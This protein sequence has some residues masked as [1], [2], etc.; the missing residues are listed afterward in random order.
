MRVFPWLAPSVS[1]AAT[2]NTQVNGGDLIT[3]NATP[4]NGGNY[5]S[6]QW[7]RNSKDVVGALSYTWGAKTL[8]DKDVICL[9][10]TSSYL[11]PQPKTASSNCITVSINT[12][13]ITDNKTMKDI[14]IYPNPVTNELVIEGIT[15]DTR[16][17][18]SD[19][20]GR[21]VISTISTNDKTIL[22][23]SAL[24]PGTY[25]L[26]LTNEQGER[27]NAKVVKD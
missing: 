6:Y 16:I 19:I 27:M 20:L 12:T 5:P 10:M 25:L 2:P 8:D 24:H 11:C 18:L 7:K 1:I 3:F 14:S 13:G 21:V 26:Q 9:V 15:K 23:T 22:N 4:V 17:Q